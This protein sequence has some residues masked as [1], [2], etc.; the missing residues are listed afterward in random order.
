MR[1][2]AVQLADVNQQLL[3]GLVLDY[4]AQAELIEVH[5]PPA[6]VCSCCGRRSAVVTTADA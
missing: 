4:L 1:E 2:A 6:A 5:M 3:D